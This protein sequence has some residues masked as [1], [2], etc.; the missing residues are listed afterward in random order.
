MMSRHDVRPRTGRND[1]K[2]WAL[3]DGTKVV[4]EKHAG[5]N[6][7]THQGVLPGAEICIHV[8]AGCS[9]WVDEDAGSRHDDG[10]NACQTQGSNALSFVKEL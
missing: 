10:R 1:R 5:T 7:N 3:C 2:D 4:D 8:G 6:L 9:R